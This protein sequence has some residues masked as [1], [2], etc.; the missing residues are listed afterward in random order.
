M[1]HNVAVLDAILDSWRDVFIV[2]PYIHI[3]IYNIHTYIYIYRIPKDRCVCCIF[4]VLTCFDHDWQLHQ[5]L[6]SNQGH[7]PPDHPVVKGVGMAQD[8]K[9]ASWNLQ[10]SWASVGRSM[11]SCNWSSTF[12]FASHSEQAWKSN[13]HY[14]EL[15]FAL[16]LNWRFETHQHSKA[17][18]IS[19]I[20]FMISF[21]F[22]HTL[23]DWCD[24]ESRKPWVVKTCHYCTP[25]LLLS[26]DV[27]FFSQSWAGF[28]PPRLILGPLS[29]LFLDTL[30]DLDYL[31]KVC[32]NFLAPEQH[33]WVEHVM[34]APPCAGVCWWCASG[35]QPRWFVCLLEK[36]RRWCG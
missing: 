4:E 34:W 13:S 28:I 3:K 26:W 21:S 2:P 7:T 36:V 19:C 5:W 20:P 24:R 14:G 30:F 16:H 18:I 27:T 29:F 33:C 31:Q 23:R 12:H 17:S 15:P 1:S 11:S 22:L 9:A 6:W 25:P 8:R 10:L 35:S 32:L